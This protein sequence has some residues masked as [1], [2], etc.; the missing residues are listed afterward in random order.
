[1]GGRIYIDRWVLR[2]ESDSVK[3]GILVRQLGI[4]WNEAEGQICFRDSTQPELEIFTPDESILQHPVLAQSSHVRNQ[5][6]AQAGR[7]ELARRLRITACCF[8]VCALIACLASMITGA[9]VRSLAAS[10][11]PEWEKT[12]GDEQIQELR[13]QLVF[14]DDSNQ[15]ARLTALA[16]PLIKAVP[17]GRTQFKFHV[18]ESKYPNAFALPGGHIVITTALLKMA[19]RPE[20]LLGVIGHEMGTLRSTITPVKSSRLPGRW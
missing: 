9:M 11:P 17:A 19:D 3:A 4:E 14:V 8:A 20:E 12:F 13:G 1:V 2:F 10:V 7:G 18:V 16:A 6:Q 5:L 15:V